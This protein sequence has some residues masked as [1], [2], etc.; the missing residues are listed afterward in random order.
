LLLHMAG[1]RVVVQRL[2][3]PD[4]GQ[5]AVPGLC[6]ATKA[7]SSFDALTGEPGVGADYASRGMLT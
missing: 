6:Q 7:N 4:V 2:V 5:R 3:Q 1:L